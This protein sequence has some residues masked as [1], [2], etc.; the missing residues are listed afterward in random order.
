VGRR[1]TVGQ[2]GESSRAWLGCPDVGARSSMS[3]HGQR[4]R[5]RWHAN[6]PVPDEFGAATGSTLAI[7][8]PM[9]E[10]PS[11][12]ASFTEASSE[13]WNLVC[14]KVPIQ[15]TLTRFE[16]PNRPRTVP[17]H[18]RAATRRRRSMPV[19]NARCPVDIRATGGLVDRGPRLRNVTGCSGC[20]SIAAVTPS[21]RS[22]SANHL[23]QR[24]G[25]IVAKVDHFIAGCGRSRAHRGSRTRCR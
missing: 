3:S 14:R 6:S 23:R 17:I 2:C 12:A 22:S 10:L 21:A 20:R 13:R 7:V 4:C 25:A 9:A 15:H 16:T 8:C 5:V 18:A 19:E 24:D 11:A 1:Y